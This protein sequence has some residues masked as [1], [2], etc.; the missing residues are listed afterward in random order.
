MFFSIPPCNFAGKSIT[1]YWE[2]FLT[3]EDIQV[4]LNQPSWDKTEE[5][6]VGNKTDGH[7][8]N[9]DVRRT[10]VGWLEPNVETQQVWGKITDVISEVNRQFFHFDL[11]GCYEPMQ[12][13][14]Y[15]AEEASHYTW[16]ADA[17]FNDRGAPRKLSM[18]LLLTDPSEFEGGELQVMTS[19]G[20]PEVLELKK[21]RA[22][23]MPS[24]TLHRVTPV[25]K[26]VR[27]S[28]VLWVGGPAFK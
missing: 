10:K 23:F 20:T 25:T 9:F 16:H 17:M 26:G 3:E 5:G 24:F 28:A 18:A 13:A 21:G 7:V 19:G 1:A 14:C 8:V 22:W 2:D 11:T 15:T 4:L 6:G 27:K 12:L